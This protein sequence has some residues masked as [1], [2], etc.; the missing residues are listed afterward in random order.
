MLD[1]QECADRCA[2]AKVVFRVVG[3]SFSS[4]IGQFFFL[5]I[6][7]F[8]IL[9]SFCDDQMDFKLIIKIQLGTLPNENIIFQKK[10]LKIRTIFW[11]AT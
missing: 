7:L 6:K 8:T 1:H 11:G 4:D 10:E 3:L 9:Y 5:K 2:T